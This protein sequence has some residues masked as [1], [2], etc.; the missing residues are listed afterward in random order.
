MLE[1]LTPILLYYSIDPGNFGLDVY[2]I[3]EFFWVLSFIVLSFGTSLFVLMRRDL[4]VKRVLV[5][6]GLPVVVMSIIA[7][8]NIVLYSVSHLWHYPVEYFIV[9]VLFIMAGARLLISGVYY[10]LKRY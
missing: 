3:V 6:F 8:Y 4:G 7:L 1:V 10:M 5:I 2:P 9:S